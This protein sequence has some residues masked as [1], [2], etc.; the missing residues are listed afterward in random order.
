M[1]VTLSHLGHITLN[2]ALRQLQ[3]DEVYPSDAAMSG[4]WKS[5]ML[6][7]WHL[8]GFASDSG[9]LCVAPNLF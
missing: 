6:N 9:T 8:L 4:K 7:F 1:E 3:T 5:F 2:E